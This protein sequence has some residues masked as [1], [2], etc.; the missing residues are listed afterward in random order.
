MSSKAFSVKNMAK[1]LACIETP[2]VFSKDM[3]GIG[4]NAGS[5]K[6]F[7]ECF[8]FLK[9]TFHSFSLPIMHYFVFFPL[10]IM[11][12]KLYKQTKECGCILMNFSQQERVIPRLSLFVCDFSFSL[13]LTQRNFLYPAEN[14][15][16]KVLEI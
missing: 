10:N 15:F 9:A 7:S 13:F 14:L 8:Y 12:S 11:G 3:Q 1:R 4:F 5:I 6:H 16:Q 2:N